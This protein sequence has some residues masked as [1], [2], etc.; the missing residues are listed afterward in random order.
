VY[1]CLKDGP[2]I[3][4]PLSPSEGDVI[5]AIHDDLVATLVLKAVTYNMVMHYLR[6]AKI[7]TSEV[8]LNPEP[9]SH[10]LDDS[11]RAILAALEDKT[12]QDKERQDKTRKD[13]ERQD[14]TRKE[15]RR[16]EKKGKIVFARATT[17]PI[18][19]YLTSY[20]L[21]K[22]HQITRVRTTSSSLGATPSVRRSESEAC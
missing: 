6:E 10:R 13:K 1:H 12:R 17:C 14:K 22:V 20:R 4:C 11:D 15:K 19:S 9:S 7:G 16:E 8:T 21:E 18:H 2:K 5:H 3:N